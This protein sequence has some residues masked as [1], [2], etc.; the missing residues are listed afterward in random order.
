MWS[1]AIEAVSVNVH[2][3]KPQIYTLLPF[4]S[5]KWNLHMYS[6]MT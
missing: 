1:P 5:E 4:I 3:S 2:R 6:I